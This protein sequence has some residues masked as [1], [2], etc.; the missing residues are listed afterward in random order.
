MGRLL[1]LLLLL[2]SRGYRTRHMVGLVASL[3]LLSC[4]DLH[5]INSSD[6]DAAHHQYDPKPPAHRPSCR[7]A[8]LCGAG[9]DGGGD[10]VQWEGGLGWGAWGGVKG[11][12]IVVVL[13]LARSWCRK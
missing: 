3:Y 1:L 5:A 9:D 8:S 2:F 7:H 13:V 4:P 6:V 12:E 11:W 10:G